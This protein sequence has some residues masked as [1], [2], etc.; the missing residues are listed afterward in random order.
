MK[1]VWLMIASILGILIIC[2]IIF[3]ITTRPR[4][5]FDEALTTA[6]QQLRIMGYE[7][8]FL[9]L[10][11]G[12]GLEWYNHG[13]LFGAEHI[14]VTTLSF[15]PKSGASEIHVQV[16]EDARTGNIISVYEYGKPYGNPVF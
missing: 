14:Y 5:S 2:I 16:I 13:K 12:T 6:K 8:P 4:V 1:R 11:M 10:S 15:Q 7:P 3:N 9:N